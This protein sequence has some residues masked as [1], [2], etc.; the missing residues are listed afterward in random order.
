MLQALG[1]TAQDEEL[2]RT[3]LRYPRST[4]EDLADAGGHATSTVRR[5]VRRLEQLGLV[6]RLAGGP[7]RFVPARP[8]VAV[9]VLVA[10]R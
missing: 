4:L 9:D 7:V 1:V 8:D 6:T 10:Q 3:L 2:Y 5:S